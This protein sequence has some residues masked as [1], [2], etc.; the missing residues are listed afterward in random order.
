MAKRLTKEE[1]ERIIL[2]Y[3]L[4]Y[5]RANPGKRCQVVPSSPGWYRV[6]SNHGAG[7]SQYRIG[8][9]VEMTERL[10]ERVERGEFTPEGL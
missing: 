10:K 4:A 1:K 5:E 9:F 2:K 3:E 7:V 8:Q 6:H